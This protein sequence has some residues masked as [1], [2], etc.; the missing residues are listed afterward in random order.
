MRPNIPESIFNPM[1]NNIKASP[2]ANDENG[3]KRFRLRKHGPQSH[4][5][6]NIRGEHNKQILRNSEYGRY[7]INR[8]HNVGA[9]NQ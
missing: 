2:F 5:G 1:N 3:V 7:R 4:D 9:F 6:K 8:K